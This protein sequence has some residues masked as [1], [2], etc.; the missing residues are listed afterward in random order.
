MRCPVT[1]GREM[2]EAVDED[3]AVEQQ[4]QDEL[5]LPRLHHA[6]TFRPACAAEARLPASISAAHAH[7]RL[8]ASRSG[9]PMTNGGSRRVASG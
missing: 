2:D 6:A 9:M 5:E 3:Q 7:S 8:P 1:V 4:E